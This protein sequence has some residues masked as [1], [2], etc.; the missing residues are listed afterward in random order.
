MPL[1]FLPPSKPRAKQLGAERQDRLSMMTALGSGIA[2][3][4]PPG[5]DQ[6][7]EQA[8]PQAG[9]SGRTACTERAE[10]NVAELADRPPLQA[11]ERHMA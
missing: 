2:A 8:A 4:L 10:R 9:S 6:A 3:S 1:I 5:Q 7:V 11:A